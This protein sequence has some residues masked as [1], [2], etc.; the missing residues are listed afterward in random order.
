MAK[1]SKKGSKYERDMSRKLS[2]WF[3]EN[4]SED[5]YWRS[6]G[7]GSRATTRAK[8]GKQ[9]TGHGGDIAATCAEAEP[10]T[11]LFAIEIKRGYASST[12]HDLLDRS[13]KSALQQFEKFVIQAYNAHVQ[14]KT[15]SWML[16]TRRDQRQALVSL[17]TVVFQRL[18]S[19]AVDHTV[20]PPCA[21][22][23]A[24]YRFDNGVEVKPEWFQISTVLLDDFIEYVLPTH[25]RELHRQW[26]KSKE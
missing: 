13:E 9:T 15:Y 2:L 18:R 3:S 24:G 7:S 11:Q 12:I 10:L 19:F 5:W 1:K 6:A 23:V 22:H 17:P 16:I 14:Q 4:E 20:V 21:S 26:K 25:V 8:Q